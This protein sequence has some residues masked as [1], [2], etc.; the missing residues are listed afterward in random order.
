MTGF[1]DPARRCAPGIVRFTRSRWPANQVTPVAQSGGHDRSRGGRRG[2]VFAVHPCGT[3]AVG[4]APEPARLI[5]E[6]EHA[7]ASR[8]TLDL[9]GVGVRGRRFGWSYLIS[10]G[11]FDGPI[12]LEAPTWTVHRHVTLIAT[13]ELQDYNLE[14][15][16][17]PETRDDILLLSDEGTASS[18]PSSASSLKIPIRTL[19]RLW[20]TPRPG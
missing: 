14:G 7:W 2:W 19:P 18:T 6:N 3:S 20:L 8:F 13:N 11:P 9:G 10:A 17:K 4:A 1:D 16:F 15:F 12:E 5:A